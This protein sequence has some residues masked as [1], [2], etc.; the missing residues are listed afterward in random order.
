[1]QNCSAHRHRRRRHAAAP[2]SS[3]ITSVFHLSLSAQ[4]QTARHKLEIVSHVAQN[5]LRISALTLLD[6]R[7][8]CG[9]LTTCWRLL[10]CQSDWPFVVCRQ[11]A[12]QPTYCWLLSGWMTMTT[13]TTTNKNRLL[14]NNFVTHS[15][16]T[17]F[18]LGKS[19]N[20]SFATCRALLI[21]LW[22]NRR[23][24]KRHVW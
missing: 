7:T 14:V 4:R 18:S 8:R 3:T 12:Y 16:N 2:E 17:C 9:I 20:G 22:P 21:R 1:M 23:S 10:P 15:A 5:N 19:G 24:G 11:P 6:W 13:T